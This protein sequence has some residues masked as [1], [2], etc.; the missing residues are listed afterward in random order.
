[1]H[2]ANHNSLIGLTYVIK[3]FHMTISFKKNSK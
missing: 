3:N 1:M 2:E